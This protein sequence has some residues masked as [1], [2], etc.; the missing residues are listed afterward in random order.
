MEVS[1]LCKVYTGK[2]GTGMTDEERDR[3]WDERKE[4]IGREVEISYQTK[5][6]EGSLIFP[7]FCRIRYDL[8]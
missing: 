2:V 4:L 3:I 1:Q 5:T 7:V 8:M 6:R